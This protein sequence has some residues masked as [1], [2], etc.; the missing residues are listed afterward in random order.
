[1]RVDAVEPGGVAYDVGIRAGD[2]LVGVD[3]RPV[4][5]V[6][7]LEQRMAVERRSRELGLQVLREGVVT[8][9]FLATSPRQRARNAAEPEA[10]RNCA[11]L[12]LDRDA[13]VY[14]ESGCAVSRRTL[15]NGCSG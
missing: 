11:S 8:E 14:R 4:A 12:T 13:G 15:C 10:N 3:R 1:L 5:T 2:L 7:E 6:A 9:T